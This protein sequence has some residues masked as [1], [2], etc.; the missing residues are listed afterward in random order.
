V[1][2]LVQILGDKIQHVAETSILSL[3]ATVKFN[4]GL[5]A[6]PVWTVGIVFANLCK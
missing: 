5:D 6:L 1:I 2:E 4:L 3:H